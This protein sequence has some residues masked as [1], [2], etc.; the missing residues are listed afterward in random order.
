MRPTAPA[1]STPELVVLDLDG[2]LVRLDVDWQDIREQI[3]RT[4]AACAPSA[5][6]RVSP[7]VHATLTA[8]GEH[9]AWEALQ[10]CEQLVAEAERRAAAEAPVNRALLRWLFTSAPT[11]RVAILTLND[12][13]AALA[14]TAGLGLD[15]R[16]DPLDVLGRGDAPAKPDPRGLLRVLARHGV[17]PA[18]ALLIGDSETDHACGAAAGVSTLDV[19]AIGAE[20]VRQ[21]ALRDDDY[22]AERP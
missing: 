2:T 7:G 22:R 9:R 8:L 21:E 20:W 4:V 18:G 3:A 11:A 10:A 16:L 6:G 19:S 1:P 5:A 15:D 12:R 13:G 14:A 17:A